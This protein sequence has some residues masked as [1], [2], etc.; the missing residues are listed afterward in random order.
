VCEREREGGRERK[1]EIEKQERKLS[2]CDFDK[3]EGYR[4]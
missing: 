3:I 2:L 4:N 1:R